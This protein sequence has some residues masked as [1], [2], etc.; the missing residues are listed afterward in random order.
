MDS[1]DLELVSTLLKW[2]GEHGLQAEAVLA[3]IQATKDG[4]DVDEA[5]AYAYCEWDL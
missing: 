2:A 1:K 4:L 3:V 5:C